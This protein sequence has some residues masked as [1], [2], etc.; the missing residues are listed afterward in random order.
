M[1]EEPGRI[2]E[3]CFVFS[4]PDGKSNSVALFQF[5]VSGIGRGR[6][7]SL[8]RVERRVSPV[9]VDVGVKEGSAVVQHMHVSRRQAEMYA[10]KLCGHCVR[11]CHRSHEADHAVL[12]RIAAFHG[13]LAGANRPAVARSELRLLRTV[14]RD[15]RV[16][17]RSGLVNDTRMPEADRATGVSVPVEAKPSGIER[18]RR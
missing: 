18:I 10:F 11:A 1:G 6:A 12:S 8:D 7:C 16:V 14:V 9:A 4:I 13:D 17:T 3:V 5:D 2:A 15:V